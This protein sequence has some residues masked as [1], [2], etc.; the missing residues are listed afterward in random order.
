VQGCWDEEERVNVKDEGLEG[1]YQQVDRI[2][3]VPGRCGFEERDKVT[4]GY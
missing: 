4:R 2:Y 3:G 1:V